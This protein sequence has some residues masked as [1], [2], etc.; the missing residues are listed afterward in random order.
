M[1][2]RLRSKCS[3]YFYSTGQSFVAPDGV[4]SSKLTSGSV[5]SHIST[6]LSHSGMNLFR[7]L[8]KYL[9]G[10]VHPQTMSRTYLTCGSISSHSFH[11]PSFAINSTG[12][13]QPKVILSLSTTFS[14]HQ[15]LIGVSQIYSRQFTSDG[16]ATRRIS[17]EKL[18]KKTGERNTNNRSLSNEKVQG[19]FR[20]TVHSS[21]ESE[22]IDTLD[23]SEFELKKDG[24]LGSDSF[25]DVGVTPSLCKALEEDKITSPTSVQSLSLPITIASK[26]HCMIRSETGSGKTLVFLLPALQEKLPGLTTLIVVPTRELAVQIF[27]QA[28]QLNA[29]LRANRRKRIMSL[30]TGNKL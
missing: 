21:F 17:N 27:Y 10:T 6:G 15:T 22:S 30:Y 14:G 9:R 13:H 25:F 8:T 4:H 2:G 7:L 29:N 23:M 19:Q 28:T 24:T 26:R 3:R 16:G 12:E 18:V 5:E 1:L 11:L 20:T